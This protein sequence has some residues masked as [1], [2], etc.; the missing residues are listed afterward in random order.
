[1]EQSKKTNEMKQTFLSNGISDISTYIQLS[2]T[3][4]SII[5]GTLVALIAG[6]L[7]CYIPI[8]EAFSKINPCSWQGNVI[9]L[10]TLFHLI[11]LIMSFV[12]G[13]FTI[14]VHVSKITYK[15]KWFLTQQTKEY[16]FETYMKDVDLMTDKDII[17]NM[18]AE[19]YELND[20]NR[21]KSLAAKWTIRFL[22]LH[23]VQAPSQCC[24]FSFLFCEVIIM[25]IN[26]EEIYISTWEHYK[27]AKENLIIKESQKQLFHSDA[28]SNVIPGFDADKLEFGS[29]DKENYAVLFVD[30][31]GS[32]KRA[33]CVG[34]EKTFLTMHIFLTALLEVV[35]HYKGK[36]IDI[37]GDGLMVFWGGKIARA[38]DNMVKSIAVQ[39]AG[40]CGRDMIKVCSSVINPFKR[41]FFAL[42]KR[43]FVL[44]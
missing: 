2:D 25:A 9:I 20:I 30:M 40:L 37:M 28:I 27:K 31:R 8:S 34:P 16:Y 5:M 15:S 12:F 17:E 33:Q 3:K 14:R 23:L 6:F 18:A 36:V 29:Y 43:L 13:I 44:E 1:M 10:F 4:V 42:P 38:K 39:N 7:A 11:S 32:T 24:Y 22:L 35:K 26:L 21:Q 41:R 19:L